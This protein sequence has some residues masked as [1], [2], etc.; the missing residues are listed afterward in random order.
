MV[1]VAAV[2]V[3]QFCAKTFCCKPCCVRVSHPHSQHA[4]IGVSGYKT[5]G[6]F[7][8]VILVGQIGQRSNQENAEK[9]GRR[10][11]A[12]EKEANENEDAIHRKKYYK[13]N[14]YF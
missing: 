1:D 2:D 11:A 7:I 10:H 5:G 14:N 3:F 4:M 12:H 9:Q 8:V 13:K 6:W